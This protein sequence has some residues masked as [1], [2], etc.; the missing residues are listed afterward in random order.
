MG[1]AL[2]HIGE[3]EYNLNS[4]SMFDIRI[5]QTE[6]DEYTTELLNSELGVDINEEF[7]KSVKIAM[8]KDN[9][10]LDGEA[11]GYLISELPIWKH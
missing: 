8:I 4:N 9:I 7:I 3:S 10:T 1:R 6:D 5:K 2:K 11:A